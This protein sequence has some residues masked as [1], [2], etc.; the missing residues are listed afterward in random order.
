MTLTATGITLLGVLLSIGVSVALGI[1]GDWW[2]R[3]LAGAGSTLL[4]VVV[5]KLASR[6]GRGPLSRLAKWA[7]SAPP[8]V[9][10]E[11]REGRRGP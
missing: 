7:I 10:D 11:R 1:E 8:A 2:L 4:L 9:V 6:S 5:V 3:I